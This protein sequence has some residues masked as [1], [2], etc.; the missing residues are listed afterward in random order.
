MHKAQS[1]NFDEI[2]MFE[3]KYYFSRECICFYTQSDIEPEEFIVG[4]RN[5]ANALEHT[6]ERMKAHESP[7]N[8]Q[9][10]TDSDRHSDR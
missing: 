8:N 7:D 3:L 2:Q 5:F 1:L 4:L 10:Q 6:L 9:R